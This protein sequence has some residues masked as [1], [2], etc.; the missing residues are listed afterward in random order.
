MYV[1]RCGHPGAG[2]PV[3]RG[4]HSL[5]SIADASGR[6][7]GAG[8]RKWRRSLWS[9]A[10]GAGPGPGTGWSCP[11]YARRG[12]RLPGN[13]DRAG[14]ADAPGAPRR[15]P[16]DP[17]PGRRER[18]VL[19]GP[20]RRRAG[21][22]QLR[23]HRDH[24]RG[25]PL[26]GA[27]PA[28]RLPGRGD[29]VRRPGLRR[30]VPGRREELERRAREGGEGWKLPPGPPA[31]DQAAEITEWG[32]PRRSGQ[33]VK[34]LT[35]PLRLSRGETALPG[36]T[37]T[38]RSARSQTARR[39]GAPSKSRRPPLD[40]RELHTGHTLQYTAPEETVRILT[41]S[42]GSSR[43]VA[44]S[45]WSHPPVRSGAGSAPTK[46]TGMRGD[47]PGRLHQ[48]S[49]RSTPSR[50]YFRWG[51]AARGPQGRE[52]P[53]QGVCPEGM[54][55][56]RPGAG[57]GHRRGHPYSPDVRPGRCP[58]A[59]RSRRGRGLAAPWRRSPSG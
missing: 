26:P 38:A 16:G 53:R 54:P 11:C 55:S 41:S 2:I 47:R 43:A 12:R 25:R 31:P 8:R 7:P 42:R 28:A 27:P 35:Q 13:A 23:R 19:R 59:P 45:R 1:S 32:R 5:C 3:R 34:T 15:R 24:R 56:R 9:T 51:A 30:R 10:R 49:T 18:A 29:A 37:S 21:R 40:Y 22:A 4:T 44:P 46:A 33:P 14:R 20:A 57:A 52:P 58:A 36:P 48:R 39:P 50:V 6:R 17:H